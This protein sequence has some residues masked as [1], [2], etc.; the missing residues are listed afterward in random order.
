MSKKLEG[1]LW[2]VGIGVAA[3]LAAGLAVKYNATGTSQ[4]LFDPT[5]LALWPYNLL[6]GSGWTIK[7]GVLAGGR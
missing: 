1:L 2:T 7:A 6:T 3:Y 4:G 5:D